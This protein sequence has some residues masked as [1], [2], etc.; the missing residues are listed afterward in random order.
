MKHRRAAAQYA[1][2]LCELAKE[3]AEGAMRSYPAGVAL[4]GRRLRSACSRRAVCL[5]VPFVMLLLLVIATWGL[6]HHIYFDRSG[7]PD[8][9]ALFASSSRRRAKSTTH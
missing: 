4:V 1:K 3:R 9:E 2:A 7:V 8:L 6:A 5:A